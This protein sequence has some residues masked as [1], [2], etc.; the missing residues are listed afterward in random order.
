MTKKDY[1]AIARAFRN[2]R[3]EM[4]RNKGILLVQQILGSE[5][6]A[7]NPKFN[8]CRFHAACIPTEILK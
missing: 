2:A 7:N 5:L 1:E 3:R 6:R 8:F 4:P